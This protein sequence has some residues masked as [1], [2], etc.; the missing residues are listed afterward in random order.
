MIKLPACLLLS[1]GVTVYAYT[2]DTT[3]LKTDEF[4]NPEIVN[5]PFK[6]ITIADARFDKTKIGFVHNKAVLG[7]HS[8]K[9]RI[10]VF[11]DSLH[12]YLQQ[13]IARFSQLDPTSE[14]SVFILIKKFRIAE[15]YTTSVQQTINTYLNLNLSMSFYKVKDGRYYKLFSLDDVLNE[16]VDVDFDVKLS[17][18][19]FASQRSAI[20]TKWIYKIMRYGN[21]KASPQDAGFTDADISAALA[22]RFLL[23]VFTQQAPAGLYKTFAEFKNTTPSVQNISLRYK[24]NKVQEV[25]DE[26]GNQIPAQGFWGLSDGKK[27]YL[28]F[29]NEW[30]ELL[31]IDNS[32]R[33]LSY[34]T[35]AEI[36]GRAVL[37][38]GRYQGF[39]GNWSGGA[40]KEEY[41]DLDMDSG[42]LFLEEVFGKSVLKHTETGKSK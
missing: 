36:T 41:F 42:Q 30:V 16:F 20:L 6:K 11:P 13:M 5:L 17:L 8:F 24:D 9:K 25:L 22:K 3:V 21:W 10:A 23:P 19:H 31:R 26:N 2:Q 29:R 38:D 7:M 18:N 39:L 37:G 40:K 34:R 27:N 33:V 12:T 14:E 4:F 15:N 1:L 28:L 35:W 32:Y